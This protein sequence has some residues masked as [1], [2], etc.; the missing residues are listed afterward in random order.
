MDLK[1][2]KL[3]AQPNSLVPNSITIAKPNLFIT[4]L[5]TKDKE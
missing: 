1:G 5:C 3:L 4:S 2:E